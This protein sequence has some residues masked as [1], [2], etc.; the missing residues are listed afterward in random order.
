MYKLI[1]LKDI[2]TK[3]Y[4]TM[5]KEMGKVINNYRK[6]LCAHGMKELIFL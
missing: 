1:K 2:Y 4:K 3:N 6:I 5:M